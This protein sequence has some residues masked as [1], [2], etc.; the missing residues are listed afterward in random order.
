M[1]TINNNNRK[2]STP[3]GF[4]T[5]IGWIPCTVTDFTASDT[6]YD[7]VAAPQC[8]SSFIE[9]ISLSAHAAAVGNSGVMTFVVEKVR[10]GASGTVTA[11]TTSTSIEAA[12]V[13]LTDGVYNLPLLTTLTPVDVTFQ[14][15]DVIRVKKV[16]AGTI[17][18]QPVGAKVLC[19]FA[20]GIYP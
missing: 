12:F 7:V 2:H 16:A 17:T 15:G 3:G 14:A 1:S 5:D 19:A 6:A 20:V 11:L 9:R 13:T 18:T 10:G 4:G 8:S